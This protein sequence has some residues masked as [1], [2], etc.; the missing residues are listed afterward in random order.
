MP[1]GLGNSV[2]REFVDFRRSSIE[3]DTR[4]FA[5]FGAI[6]RVDLERSQQVGLGTESGL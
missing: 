6:N 2:A 3:T 5:T 4:D 1:V